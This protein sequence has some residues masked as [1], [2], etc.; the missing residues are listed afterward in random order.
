M[1]GVGL[2]AGA[3]WWAVSIPVDLVAASS[4]STTSRYLYMAIASLCPPESDSCRMSLREL[5]GAS[6]IQDK[7]SLNRH[8]QQL[9]QH[10]WLSIAKVPGPYPSVYS[11]NSAGLPERLVDVPASLIQHRNLSP[12]AKC[13]Y[14]MIQ[15]CPRADEA[16]LVASQADL[17]KMMGLK[18]SDT[19]RSLVGELMREGWLVVSRGRGSRRYMYQPLDPHWALR[20]S[21]LRRV[22]IRIEREL[23]KGEALMREMLNVA[24]ADDRFQDNARPG[25]LINP[26]TDERLEFDRWYPEAGVA[27]EFNGLQHYQPTMLYSDADA[28]RKQRARDLIKAAIAQQRGIHLIVVRPENVTFDWLTT[29]VAGLLPVRKLRFEDPVV[30]YLDRASRA[31]V[32]RVRRVV[33][34]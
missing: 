6:G 18:S 2:L 10:G 4:L 17:A 19:V 8:L 21:A 15:G 29:R 12:G 20:E 16:G 24:I 5:A 25:F 27:F 32:R 23:Y 34:G 22:Q 31:Y 11:L 14:A 1:K 13:L 33:G 28:V 9:V 26:L 7:R 3:F 30:G